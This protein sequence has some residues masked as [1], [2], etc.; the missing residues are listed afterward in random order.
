MTTRPVRFLQAFF[1]D[2]DAQLP[3]ERTDDGTPSATDF[4]LHDLPR[5]RDLLALNF[6]HNTLPTPGGEP[7]R[8]LIQ[9][10]TLVRSAALYAI[11]AHSGEIV[12]IGLELDVSQDKDS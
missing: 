5:L 4:L 7:V 10:G 12:V 2:L 6:E 3:E 1:D 8:V 11:E 9:A